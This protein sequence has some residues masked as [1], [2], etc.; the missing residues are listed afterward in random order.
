MIK[1]RTKRRKQKN[2]GKKEKDDE[3]K[4]KKRGNFSQCRVSACSG[5]RMTIDV[6]NETYN[7]CWQMKGILEE[8]FSFWN[9]LL[10]LSSNVPSDCQNLSCLCV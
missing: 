7:C 1:K 6:R 2:K 8:S 9:S 3:R 4:K 10:L 5:K